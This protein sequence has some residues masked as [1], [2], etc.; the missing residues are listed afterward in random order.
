MEGCFVEAM[1]RMTGK[2]SGLAPAITALIA[3]FSTTGVGDG[4]GDL[5]VRY[6]TSLHQNAPNPFN[7]RTEIKFSLRQPGAAQL[8][9]FDVRGRMIKNLIDQ[10]LPAGEHSVSWNG[11]DQN[12]RPV[13]TGVYFYRL[14]AD[15]RTLTKRMLLVK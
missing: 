14:V 1:A 15:G 3:I 13:A 10:A 5:A 8:Q 11:V 12:D 7:P 9:V 4:D 2:C 6:V